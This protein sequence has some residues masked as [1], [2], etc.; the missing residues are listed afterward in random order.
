MIM[1]YKKELYQN[2]GIIQNDTV[3]CTT[4]TNI[5]YRGLRTCLPGAMG[6]RKGHEAKGLMFVIIVCCVALI[7]VLVITIRH[8]SGL[9]YW[10]R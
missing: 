9:L 1:M 6:I 3:S 5:S 8:D 7:L 2:Y 10:K 4:L